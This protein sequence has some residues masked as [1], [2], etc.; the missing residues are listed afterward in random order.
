MLVT[1][2][3]PL[4]RRDYYNELAAA[5]GAS[6]PAFDPPSD[7]DRGKR[8]SNRRLH[9]LPGMRLSYPTI[10]DGLPTAVY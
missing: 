9:T 5:I 7:D 1:D 8:C 2:D 4:L 10:T 6:L 3:H